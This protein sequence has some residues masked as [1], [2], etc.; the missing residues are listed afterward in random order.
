MEFFNYFEDHMK[1]CIDELVNNYKLIG[2]NFLKN[3]EESILNSSTRSAK[4]MKD[5]YYYWERRVY[6]ALVKM[7]LRAFLSFKNILQQPGQKTIPLFQITAEY[8]HPYL[9]TQPPIPEVEVI[10]RKIISNINDCPK[11]FWRWMDGTCIICK[12]QWKNDENV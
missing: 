4:I 10:C 12:T 3:I 9:N 5:Y 1:K 2:E 7:T 8:D 11:N 6:N